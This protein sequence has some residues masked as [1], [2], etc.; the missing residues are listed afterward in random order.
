MS[1][2]VDKM[3][4]RCVQTFEDGSASVHSHHVS[5]RISDARRA[6]HSEKDVAGDVPA[7]NS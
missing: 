3:H 1:Y 7:Q 4:H 5:D 2:V 6:K